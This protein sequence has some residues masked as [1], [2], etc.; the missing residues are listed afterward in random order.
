MV[1][2][3]MY[4]HI[5]ASSRTP[6]PI[7][8]EPLRPQHD[9][10]AVSVIAQQYS[11]ATSVSLCFPTRKR[12][13]SLFANRPHVSILRPSRCET[14]NPLLCTRACSLVGHACITDAFYQKYNPMVCEQTSRRSTIFP[15]FLTYL[16]RKYA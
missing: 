4:V 9:R 15:V 14:R 16:Q 7:P 8:S 11:S 2:S 13:I 12:K 1:R 10:P 5:R 6:P 3:N